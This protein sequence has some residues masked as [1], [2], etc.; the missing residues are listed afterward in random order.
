[1]ALLQIRFDRNPWGHFLGRMLGRR[2]MTRESFS[3]GDDWQMMEERARSSAQ[4]A[5]GT[6]GL[7]RWIRRQFGGIARQITGTE[8]IVISAINGHA[9]GVARAW[10]PNCTR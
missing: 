10:A 1:M 2:A 5:E 7:W 6:T 3:V 8:E 4:R 9:A